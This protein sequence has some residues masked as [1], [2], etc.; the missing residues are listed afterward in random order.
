M[1]H[2]PRQPRE[3][4]NVSKTHPLVEASTLVVGV[5][6]LFALLTIALVFLVEI[7]LY[8]IP[9]E[10]EKRLFNNYLPDDLITV[11]PYDERLVAT[12]DLVDSLAK[13]WPD[14]PYEF[15][16]EIHDTEAANA[17]A[18]PGGLIV[19]T[20]GLLDQVESENELAFVLGHEIGHFRNR[21]HLRALGRIA[22][23]SMVF[24]AGPGDVDVTVADLTL[25]RGRQ[26]QLHDVREG[27][28]AGVDR[29][30]RQQRNPDAAGH[31]LHQRMQTAGT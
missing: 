23:L 20:E 18:F 12:Q 7:A 10:T 22:V 15:T 30:L 31:H 14:S 13:H 19:V 25:R 17:M 27:A 16:V 8:F 28:D 2:V 26:R 29:K 6:I 5:S 1:R 11:A 9:V 24:A 21:D 3:G 4:I